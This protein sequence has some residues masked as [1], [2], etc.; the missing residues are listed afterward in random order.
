MK[1]KSKVF[2]KYKLY[3]VMMKMQWN[4]NIKSLVSDRGGE[5]TSH[6]FKNYLDKQ[7]TAQKLTIHDTPKSNGIVERLN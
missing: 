7:G 2:E 4:V 5:Y 1:N 3:E 6:E